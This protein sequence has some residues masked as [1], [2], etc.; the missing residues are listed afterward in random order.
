MKKRIGRYFSQ[1]G[2]LP[3]AAQVT[4]LDGRAIALEEFFDDAIGRVRAAHATGN[5]LIFIGNGGSAAIASHMAI[6]FAKNGGIRAVAMNDASALTCLSNDLGYER[7]FAKQIEMHARTGDVLIAISSSGNSENI[8]RAVG[9]ARDKGCAVIT[10]SGF[11]ANNAL[12]QRGDLNL[13]VSSGEYGFVEVTHLSLCHALLDIASGW[14]EAEELR[15][16]A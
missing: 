16:L 1:L 10:L 11:S 12:R 9:A 6:D 5:T 4:G 2:A 14:G 8:L 15:R 7:V 13:Y 3:L